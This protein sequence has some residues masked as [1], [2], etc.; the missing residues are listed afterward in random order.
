VSSQKD[1]LDRRPWLK[2]VFFIFAANAVVGAGYGIGKLFQLM[3][4]GH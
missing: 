1:W 2:I 3:K 4:A